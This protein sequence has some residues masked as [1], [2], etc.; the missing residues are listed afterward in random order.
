MSKQGFVLIEALA[1]IVIVSICLTLIAQSLLSNFRTGVRFQEG[2]KTL[3]AMKNRLG[4][5]Y[6]T[7]GSADQF[8]S[9]PKALESP[10]ERYSI[11]TKMEN[12]DK[13][14]KHID[15]ILSWPVSSKERRLEASTIIYNP[16]DVKIRT[17]FAK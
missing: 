6:V 8:L 10:Y 7:T 3:L 14:L 4:L 11:R 17:Y 12:L 13:H 9:A 1:A 15:L 5:L 2:V 16:D